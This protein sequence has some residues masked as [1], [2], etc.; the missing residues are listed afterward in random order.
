[1]EIISPVLVDRTV[2]LKIDGFTVLVSECDLPLVQGYEWRVRPFKELFYAVHDDLHVR[3]YMHRV[4]MGFTRGDK[5]IVD[6][7][8][9]NGLHNQRPN[10]RECTHK[11]NLWNRQIVGGNAGYFGVYEQNSKFAASFNSDGKR[12][13]LGLFETAVEAAARVNRRLKQTR[14]EFAV[15]NPIDQNE[16]RV[17]ISARVESAK[18][19][20]ADLEGLLHDAS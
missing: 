12:H 8:N 18:K 7:R 19:Q 5:R 4:I 13:Y 10:L 20:I 2:D 1:M 15:L 17:A 3:T 11:Q 16:L 6:H 9:G 14:G